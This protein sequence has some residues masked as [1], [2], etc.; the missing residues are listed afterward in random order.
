MVKG[1]EH[2]STKFVNQHLSGAVVKGVEHIFDK[3]VSQ[4]LSGLVVKGV[5]HISTPEWR[6]FESRWFYYYYS[7]TQRFNIYTK[8]GEYLKNEIYQSGFEFA[9]TPTINFNH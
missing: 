2:I 6:G 9:K 1:V 4:H 3:F 5:E 7:N 8:K